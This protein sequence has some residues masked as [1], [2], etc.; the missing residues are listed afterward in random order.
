MKSKDDRSYVLA[1]AFGHHPTVRTTHTQRPT[2]LQGAPLIL[3][4]LIQRPYGGI[5]IGDA[6]DNPGPLVGFGG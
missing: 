3:Y 5:P 2:I 6:I 1:V 4:R